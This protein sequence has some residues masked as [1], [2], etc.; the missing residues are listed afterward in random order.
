VQVSTVSWPPTKWAR[1]SGRDRKSDRRSAAEIKDRYIELIR[2]AGFQEVK[3]MEEKTYPLEYIISES[4]TEKVINSIAM[5][6]EEARDAANSVVSVKVS[7]VK[8]PQ[9]TG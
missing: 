9:Q 4:T 6:L 3:I 7:T 2:Q 5:S 8:M 1:A